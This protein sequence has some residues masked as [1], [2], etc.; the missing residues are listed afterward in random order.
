MSSQAV[1]V[2]PVRTRRE[3]RIFLTFP[4]RI[5]R[6]D[7]LWVPPLLPEWA[8]RIDPA[9]GVFFK[10]GEAEFFIAWRDGQPVGTICAAEDRQENQVRQARECVFGFFNFIEDYAVMEA[11]LGRAREW[12]AGRGLDVL[13]GPF[14]LDYEDSYGI[15]V[16]GRDRPPTLLCGHTPPYYLGF[17]ERYG[18]QPA[19]GIISLSPWI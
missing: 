6:N 10:R 12:A 5:Y 8:E 7:P 16:E 11:L 14:N 13:T 1:T 2:E 17:V 4:W 19:A 9:R 15:L 18:F 3:R